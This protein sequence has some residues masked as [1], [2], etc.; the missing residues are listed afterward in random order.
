MR[1]VTLKQDHKQGDTQYY[2]GQSVPLPDD[3][4]DWLEQVTLA[5]KLASRTLDEPAQ[6]D[7]QEQSAPQTS[8]NTA[9]L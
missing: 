8:D 4:A 2:A 7:V 9:V 3:I 1:L 5:D 6:Q